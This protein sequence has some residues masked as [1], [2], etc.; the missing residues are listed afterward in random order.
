MIQ[1]MSMAFEFFTDDSRQVDEILDAGDRAATDKA[2]FEFGRA[3][4]MRVQ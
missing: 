4:G 3:A 2:Q 1:P